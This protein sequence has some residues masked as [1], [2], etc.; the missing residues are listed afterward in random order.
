MTTTA[1]DGSFHLF[2]LLDEFAPAVVLDEED[3]QK[4]TCGKRG[5]SSCKQPFPE[6]S[7]YLILYAERDEITVENEGA[8]HPAEFVG[9]GENCQQEEDGEGILNY[10][11]D[12]IDRLIH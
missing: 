8:M 12:Q 2:L 7:S 4:Q 10:I 9:D 6:T 1:K 11:S 3:K 5:N